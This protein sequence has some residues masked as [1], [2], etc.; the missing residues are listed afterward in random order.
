MQQYELGVSEYWNMEVTPNYRNFHGENCEL[1]SRFGSAIFSDKPISIIIYTFPPFVCMTDGW[2]PMIFID[3]LRERGWTGGWTSTTNRYFDVNNT[4]TALERWQPTPTSRATARGSAMMALKEWTTI[5]LCKDA[6]LQRWGIHA[7]TPN[8]FWPFHAISME[9]WW[10]VG[11]RDDQIFREPHVI[12]AM[13]KSILCAKSMLR[14]SE[15][16]LR[17]A[18]LRMMRTQSNSGSLSTEQKK[19]HQC[20][21]KTGGMLWYV[22]MKCQA[23]GPAWCPNTICCLFLAVITHHLVV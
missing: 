21:L 20:Q 8:I 6:S 12:H 10:L 22:V 17:H 11:I 9:K 3:F 16:R 15:F 23:P 7:F 2:T 18:T 19:I 14:R 1:T 4:V 5:G 13:T